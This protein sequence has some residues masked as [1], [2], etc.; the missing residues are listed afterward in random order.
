MW[1]TCYN[2]WANVDTLTKAYGLHSTSLL[3]LYI[4]WV[5]TEYNDMY[6]PW[7][8]Y[9]EEF[10]GPESPLGSAILLV[11]TDSSNSLQSLP[12]LLRAQASPGTHRIGGTSGK[13]PACQCR[14][15]RDA[16]SI[17]GLERSPGG[18]HGNPLQYSCLENPMDRGTWQAT[19]HR[20]TKN[21]TRLKWL[22]THT[23]RF[24]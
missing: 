13:E 18:G 12:R 11:I 22:S 9:T 8:Y 24:M 2:G 17:P 10:H 1:Y 16:G 23:H 20:V 7:Q 14:R 21:W 3:L 5:L 4:P 15:L 6:P 19:A